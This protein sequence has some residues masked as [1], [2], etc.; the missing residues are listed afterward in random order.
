MEARAEPHMKLTDESRA[1][2]NAVRSYTPGE[3]RVGEASYTRSC[4]LAADS[5]VPDWPPQTIDELRSEHLDAVLALKPEVVI[6]G[7]GPRQQFPPA[8][9]MSKV[10]SRGVGFEVMDTGAACRT[11][12]ILIAEDRRA[13]AALFL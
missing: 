3:L 9:L 12:N 6:L 11:F 10:L 1:V 5:I 7:T 13:V 2:T 8:A 4:L